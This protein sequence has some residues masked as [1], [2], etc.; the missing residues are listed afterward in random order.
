MHNCIFCKIVAGEIPS[1]KLY[2][3]EQ[4]LA[5]LDIGPLVQGHSLVIPRQ[6][7][8]PLTSAPPDILTACMRTVQRV[9]TALQAALGADGVNIHQANGTA[10]GQVVPHL[11]FHVIP[12][13]KDDG[14]H[15]NW[16]AR[17]Y[18]SMDTMQQMAQ[19]ITTGFAGL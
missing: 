13:F 4:T 1:C 2:E 5:F 9:M 16:K 10:A 14:H 12:R 8:D 3:D 15:W 18:A 7:F 19:R 11:H 17:S 6:H